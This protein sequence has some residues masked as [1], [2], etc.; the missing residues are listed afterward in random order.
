[1][2][3]NSEELETYQEDKLHEKKQEWCR[4]IQEEMKILV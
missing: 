4:A 3:N 1:M 2:L